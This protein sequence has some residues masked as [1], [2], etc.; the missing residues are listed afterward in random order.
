M[1]KANP[2]QRL[3]HELRRAS[4]ARAV[5]ASARPCRHLQHAGYWTDLARTLERGK[6]DALFLADV[7]GVYDVYNGSPDTALENAV[8]VP[9]NDPLMP[10][11]GDGGGHANIWA[12]A[13]PARCPTNI[14]TRSRGGMSTLDHLT[15]GR[16][17]WN[18]VTGYLDSA[19]R[20]HGDGEA[21]RA[22]TSA[23][24]SPRTTCRSSTSCGKA[25]WEDG[26][27]L[28]DRAG[29]RFADAEQDPPHPARG[30]AF[31]GGCDPSVRAVAA[32][33][34]GA[35]SRPAPPRAAA[36]SRRATPSACS[37]TARRRR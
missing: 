27:V 26:A 5:D 11:S 4:V 30:P 35:V 1:P 8:Q 14:P 37:S 2:P 6:F 24:T 34:A 29:R 22:T 13:S 12:S 21:G 32:A 31:Q 36:N 19:A 20:G 7:L 28:R 17:G 10:I 3:R 33:D 15:R 25:S 23:T 18:I 16:I 9:V